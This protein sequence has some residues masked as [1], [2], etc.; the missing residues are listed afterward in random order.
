MITCPHN[1]S[2]IGLTSLGFLLLRLYMYIVHYSQTLAWHWQRYVFYREL[3]L[4]SFSQ[5]ASGSNC[6]HF[7]SIIRR[8]FSTRCLSI[9][10]SSDSGKSSCRLRLWYSTTPLKAI[11]K[12]FSSGF[13]GLLV[14]GSS[15]HGFFWQ[16]LESENEIF[17][18]CMLGTPTFFSIVLRT[19]K[20]Y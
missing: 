12:S 13:F 20:F 8:Q 11:I 1:C 10:A 2:L 18:M 4:Y 7:Q 3:R 19:R 16:I 17:S 9:N 15:M 5:L 6:R 14:G